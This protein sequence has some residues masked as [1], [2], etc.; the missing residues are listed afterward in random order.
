MWDWWRYSSNKD[1]WIIGP[2][3]PFASIAIGMKSLLLQSKS[4][5]MALPS[6]GGSALVL[7]VLRRRGLSHFHA[8]VILAL[9]I[10]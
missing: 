7:L 8:S 6:T 1:T 3:R 4:P 5:I 2:S 9:I 10:V